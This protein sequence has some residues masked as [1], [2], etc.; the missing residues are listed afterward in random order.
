MNA[1]AAPESRSLI[2]SAGDAVPDRG[3]RAELRLAYERRGE[4]TVLAERAHLGPL[5]VRNSVDIRG[6]GAQ[7][8]TISGGGTVR[9]FEFA[10]DHGITAE[11]VSAFPKEVTPQMVLNFVS[12]GA[13]IRL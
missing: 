6:P 7:L 10:G 13:A 8:L 1:V 11:G 12:G 3:W 4:R 5:V 9:V 2:T